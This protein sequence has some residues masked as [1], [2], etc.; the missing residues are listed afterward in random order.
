MEGDIRVFHQDDNGYVA[1]V[2]RNGGYVLK[3]R[4]KHGYMLHTAECPHL[5]RESPSIRLTKTP[6]VWG[7]QRDALLAWAR[8]KTGETPTFCSTCM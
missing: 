6:R 1:W 7:G 2:E 4:G 3:D 5:G 8:A